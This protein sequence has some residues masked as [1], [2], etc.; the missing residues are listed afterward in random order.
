[1]LYWNLIITFVLMF[2]VFIYQAEDGILYFH[3]TGVQTCALPIWLA[4]RRRVGD[5]RRLEARG[6]GDERLR[7]SRTSGPRGASGRIIIGR[8]PTASGCTRAS[9][10]GRTRSEERRVG[11]E[12][13]QRTPS[14]HI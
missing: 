5:R 7:A 8:L 2:I 3:V 9:M 13:A 1:M 4:R 14:H 11:K 10:R 12:W 6:K